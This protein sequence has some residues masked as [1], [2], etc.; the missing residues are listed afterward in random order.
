MNPMPFNILGGGKVGKTLGYLWQHHGIAQLAGVLNRSLTSSQAAVDFIQAGQAIAQM[1]D[2]PPA[3]VF[4][5]S[6]A[7][8]QLTTCCEALAL[9]GVLQAGNVVLHCSGALSSAILQPAK[10]V[11]AHIASIHPIKSFAEPAQVIHD[12]AGTFCGME[13]DNAALRLLEPWFTQLDARTFRID[14]QQ[15][16]LYHTASVMACNYLVALQEI[17]LQT[18]SQAGVERTLA[19]QIL[20]PIVRGTVDNVF[21]LGTANALTGPIARGDYRVV[22]RQLSALQRWQPD[23]AE[24]YRLLGK[25]AVELSQQQGHATADDLATLREVLT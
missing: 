16:T 6:C 2:L 20:N 3:D 18:F 9:S 13:G 8:N 22:E 11:G 21:R 17:S 7:D 14:P 24:I 5:L 15:K 12:F 19:M 10:D 1:Q 25:A 4:L 23:F